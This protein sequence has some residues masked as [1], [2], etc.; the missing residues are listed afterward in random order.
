MFPHS[1]LLGD[2]PLGDQQRHYK[3]GEYIYKR[4]TN[5]FYDAHGLCR[6]LITAEWTSES[7]QPSVLSIDCVLVYTV[8]S[9]SSL[10]LPIFTLYWMLCVFFIFFRFPPFFSW[11]VGWMGWICFLAIAFG[12]SF[13]HL[14]TISV[15]ILY[16]T[17]SLYL[18]IY[19]H[20][21]LTNSILFCLPLCM[22]VK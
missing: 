2:T 16:K 1:E 10:V 9:L 14:A 18:P 17:S 21:S 22:C 19:V 3:P 11:L 20:G 5:K 8:W 7:P 15:S 6:L 13:F 12:L 4:P